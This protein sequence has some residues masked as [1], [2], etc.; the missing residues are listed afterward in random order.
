MTTV[1][2]LFW[3]CTFYFFISFGGPW[4]CT[5]SCRAAKVDCVKRENYISF[6]A[7]TLK[8]NA[9]VIPV[10]LRPKELEGSFIYLF[11]VS[12]NLMIA[13]HA[14]LPNSVSVPQIIRRTHRFTHQ[15]GCTTKW[16]EWV[17]KLKSQRFPCYKGGFLFIHGKKNKHYW[18]HNLL[19]N[20]KRKAEVNKGS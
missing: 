15:R 18:T 4:L 9:H 19:H 2:A 10:L 1:V 13:G 16:A 7:P 3:I 5:V 20:L 6:L 11:S 17:N 8:R 12:Q 14:L